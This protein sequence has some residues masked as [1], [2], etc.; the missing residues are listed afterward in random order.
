MGSQMNELAG[1]VSEAL[2]ILHAGHP[3][4]YRGQLRAVTLGEEVYSV[5]WVEPRDRTVIRALA[6]AASEAPHF[7]ADQQLS[8]AAYYLLSEER[9]ENLR[10]LPDELIALQTGLPLDLI[11]RRRTLPRVDPVR[12]DEPLAAVCA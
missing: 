9:W 11:Q 2:P 8:F 3:V 1:Q 7:S 12:E 4:W 5:G 6:L 10:H